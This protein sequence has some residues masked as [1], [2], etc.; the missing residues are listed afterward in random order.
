MC[1]DVYWAVSDLYLFINEKLYLF[2]LLG[3]GFYLFLIHW[4]ENYPLLE[5][6]LF[7]DHSKIKEDYSEK[8][9]LSILC[10]KKQVYTTLFWVFTFIRYII[11][12]NQNKMV[13]HKIKIK[14]T[15]IYWVSTMCQDLSSHCKGNGEVY[16]IIPAL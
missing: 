1:I 10:L 3:S 5:F 8:S 13:L 12:S 6:S 16:F 9:I 7:Q 15:N 14:S 2:I 4:K 11:I